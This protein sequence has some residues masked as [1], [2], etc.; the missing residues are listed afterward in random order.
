MFIRLIILKRTRENSVSDEEEDVDYGKKIKHQKPD[1]GNDTFSCLFV[2]RSA[3]VWFHV[4]TSPAAE[5]Q[6]RASINQSDP[7]RVRSISS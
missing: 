3:S 5:C 7:R 4:V 1:P 6:R 2:F